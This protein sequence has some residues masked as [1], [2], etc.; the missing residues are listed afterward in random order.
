MSDGTVRAFLAIPPDAAWTERA[1]PLVAA[2]RR[3]LPDASWTR[4]ESWH[5][6][7]RFLGAISPETVARIEAAA[8]EAAAALGPAR[9]VARGAAVLPR[10]GPARVAGI[11]L[12]GEGSLGDLAAAAESCARRAGIAPEAKPFRPHVT[13][14]RIRRPWPPEALARFRVAADR[15]ELPIWPVRSFALYR[16]ELRPEGATHA[17]IARWEIPAREGTLA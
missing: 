15:W 10:R 5:V 3:D 6:T 9:L 16:S 8:G 13:L 17:A 11:A 12:E 4:P 14:A 1:R 2:L 7:L